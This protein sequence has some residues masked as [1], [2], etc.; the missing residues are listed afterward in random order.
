MNDTYEQEIDL[1][2]LLFF[3]LRKWHFIAC[4][5]I[6]GALLAGG[7]QLFH[8]RDTEYIAELKKDYDRALKEYQ[9]AEEG[10]LKSMEDLTADIH[11]EESYQENSL[12]YN[13]DPY[14]KLTSSADIFIT[15]DYSR[16]QEG[17]NMVS[18]DPADSVLKAYTSA[19]IRGIFLLPFS[20]E[21]KLDINYLKELIQ[22]SPDYNGNMLTIT[23]TH[24]ER[25][26]AEKILDLILNAMDAI[27]P[28]IQ[29]EL[30]QHSMV[31]MNKNTD[32]VI[33]P[34]LARN[35]KDRTAN[36]NN[37]YTSLRETQKA[38][39]DLTQP[40]EPAALT[41]TGI[42]K[43]GI[44]YGILGGILGAFLSAFVS[45]VLFLM[46]NTLYSEKDLKNKFGLRILGTF[47]RGKKKVVFT[48]VDE[49][50]DRLEGKK[51]VT[52]QE[53]YERIAANIK[54][55]VEAGSKILL[56]GTINETVLNDIRG[57]LQEQLCEFELAAG[58]DINDNTAALKMLN[59]YNNIVLV[60]ER[61][62]SKFSQ[63]TSEIEMVHDLK[64]NVIGCIL[65]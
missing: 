13:I 38:L 47:F 8:Y 49:Y 7:Y 19:I 10:Y 54:S 21:N 50:L 6:I 1:K 39:E 25:E 35:Q 5:A 51:N 45:S 30:G 36:L 14:N 23:V 41:P 61:G 48:A 59:E 65:L 28:E 55:F 12:L 3:I 16:S 9:Q 60:E 24:T 29:K 2:D 31:I 63:V 42:I 46:S 53:V 64:K 34:G 43:A 15:M 17:T 44:K 22:V 26:S 58:P 4:I 33:D 18:I 20:E 57:S 27:K 40:E 32:I 37:L 62:V 11:Y 56:T 52:D